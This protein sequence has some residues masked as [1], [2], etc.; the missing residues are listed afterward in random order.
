[1]RASQPAWVVRAWRKGSGSSLATQ[2]CS[3]M[4]RSR[5]ISGNQVNWG[6]TQSTGQAHQAPNG[7]PMAVMITPPSS[8]RRLRRTSSARMGSRGW[9][10]LRALSRAIRSPKRC[11]K[12]VWPV[13]S[14]I[15]LRRK[16]RGVI[17]KGADR[18]R[19][20]SSACWANLWWPR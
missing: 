9:P 2:A 15:I 4:L 6:R 5:V 14:R 12:A 18:T 1:M 20:G 11:L 17:G 19:S 8:Q 10:G 16:D 7:A 13:R 3:A